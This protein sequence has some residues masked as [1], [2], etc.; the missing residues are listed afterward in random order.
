MKSL[1]FQNPV[2]R[3]FRRSQRG[4]SIV[5]LA[6]AFLALIAFVG[7]VTDVAMMFVR[8]AAL[9]RAVDSA[10]IAAAGQIREGT[11]YAEVTMAAE[12]YIQLHGIDPDTVLVE[13]CETDIYQWRVGLG[14]WDGEPHPEEYDGTG[15]LV[16][17][18]TQMGEDTELCNWDDPRK[19][20]RVSAQITSPTSFLRLFGFDDFILEATSL[21]ETA[22]LDVALVIDTSE[23]MS[24]YTYLPSATTGETRNTI[25]DDSGLT[26]DQLPSRCFGGYGGSS[27][28]K[29]RWGGCCNDVGTGYVGDGSDQSNGVFLPNG[30]LWHDAN[31]NGLYDPG[32]EGVLPGTMSDWV[33]YDADPRAPEEKAEYFNFTTL[34]C[35]PFKQVKDAARLFIKRLDFVRG[36]RVV[37]VT[38]DRN[39]TVYDPDGT[40][41]TFR[42]L[43][44]SESV[45]IQTLNEKIGVWI[46]PNQWQDWDLCQEELSSKMAWGSWTDLGSDPA[47]EPDLRP[48]AYE[49]IAPCGNTNIGGGIRSAVNAL[50]DP[51]DIRREAVWVMIVL[52]DGAANATDRSV[53]TTGYPGIEERVYGGYGYC[54]WW[55]FCRQT[56]PAGQEFEGEPW[57]ECTGNNPSQVEYSAPACNDDQSDTRHFCLDADLEQEVGNVE[58]GQSGH[59]DADDYAR[60]MADFAGL[61]SIADGKPGNYI[62]MYSIA[63]GEEVINAATG[64]PLLRY[65]ADAGDNGIIDNNTEQDWR[66]DRALNGS[67]TAAELGVL[68]PCTDSDTGNPLDPTTQCGQYYYATDQASLLH[69]FE[70]IASRMFTRIS[71]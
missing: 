12:Q 38:F 52:S 26:P 13:T 45:A 11:N 50:T 70:Q 67:L 8:Y 31:A 36:D 56:I 9:R 3:R 55:T 69:V 62:A 18:A 46:N 65:I 27:P 19:L 57:P 7:L 44:N 14:P 21:S 43:I 1:V 51:D 10:A 48:Y 17:V 5:L 71:R 47:T 41:S 60:D 61:I 63:F 30:L 16:S 39:G 29:Y 23:S 37:F 64:A 15:N 28:Y 53:D 42:P 32:E 6:I 33:G 25:Y 34:V 35:E 58:C 59:Y 54:P 66:D 24:K 2:A 22:V 68:D 20:V 49:S 40:E 4:Q